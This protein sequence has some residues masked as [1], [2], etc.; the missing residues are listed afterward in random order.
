MP[1]NAVGSYEI[2][3][4]I[5]N[6]CDVIPTDG[7][8]IL[9]VFSLCDIPLRIISIFLRNKNEHSVLFAVKSDPSKKKF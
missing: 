8:D 3:N 7:G 9:S 2:K 6:S 5:A 1:A 4:R